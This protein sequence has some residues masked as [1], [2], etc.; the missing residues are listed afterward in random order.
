MAKHGDGRL[1]RWQAMLREQVGNGAIGCALLPQFLDDILRWKQVLELLRTT[2]REFI[3]CFA[4][5]GW[6]K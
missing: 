4:N 1:A 6:I 5:G 2:R 3:D